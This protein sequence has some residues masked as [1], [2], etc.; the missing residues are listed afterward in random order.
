MELSVY[1]PSTTVVPFKVG[2]PVPGIPIEPIYPWPN[3]PYYNFFWP[4]ILHYTITVTG[5]S[6]PPIEEPK[7]IDALRAEEV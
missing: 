4:P 6:W 5:T 1:E 7:T 3:Y 2:N